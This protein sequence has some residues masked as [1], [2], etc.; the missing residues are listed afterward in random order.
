MYSFNI[1]F[2]KVI[3]YLYCLWSYQIP[4]N[5]VVMMCRIINTLPD[6]SK[7]SASQSSTDIW[8]DLGID[9]EIKEAIAMNNSR[10]PKFKMLSKS[11]IFPDLLDASSI[12]EDFAYPEGQDVINIFEQAK[13]TLKLTSNA[14]YKKAKP[15]LIAIYNLINEYDITQKITN[16]TLT[17]IKNNIEFLAEL[18]N[19]SIGYLVFAQFSSKEWY[20]CI[21]LD[22]DL[23]K[24]S[25][26]YYSL[27]KILKINEK[28]KNYVSTEQ[29]RICIYDLIYLDMSMEN[30]NN[31][32]LLEYNTN[33]IN[34][35]NNIDIFY[36]INHLN[37]NNR[38]RTIL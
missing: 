10:N 25:A 36:R 15:K 38:S 30:N 14:L 5:P 37:V 7:S 17:K 13:I 29:L 20:L 32:I 27:I 19:K 16:I 3:S 2:R 28:Y 33:N 23:Y 35:I 9:S 31:N 34:I 4:N 22:D 1:I 8:S 11:K 12:I 18:D 21:A 6:R 26:D 24:Y